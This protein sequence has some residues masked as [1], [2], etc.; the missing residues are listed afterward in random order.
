[1]C[2]SCSVVP[3]S[4]TPLT[5]AHQAPL[6]IELS[7]QEYW[8]GLLFPFP[9]DLLNPEIEPG[10]PTLQ[11]DSLPTEPP[12]QVSSV[13]QS[14]PTLCSPRDCSMPGLPVHHQHPEFTQTHVHWVGDDIQSF[15]PLSSPS[16]PTF[17]LS[18]HQDPF[19]WVSSSI[20]WP[21][22]WNFGFNISPSNE[23]SGLIS[24]RMDWL[25]IFSNTTVQK[26]HF[27]GT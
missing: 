18:L 6:C 15:H 14:C 25:S 5:A 2:V 23:Y 7:R 12:V 26:S 16:P 11:A 10:A 1:M 3:Y 8:S 24:F 19:Q 27:F 13:V 17:S 20:R 9:G 21:K 4:A 22:Y